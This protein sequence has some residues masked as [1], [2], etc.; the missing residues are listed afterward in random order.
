MGEFEPSYPFADLTV[1]A[2]RLARTDGK[3]AAQASDLREINLLATKWLFSGYPGRVDLPATTLAGGPTQLSNGFGPPSPSTPNGRRERNANEMMASM[4]PPWSRGIAFGWHRPNVVQLSDKFVRNR[5][6][7]R[8]SRLDK[9]GMVARWYRIVLPPFVDLPNSD[10]A[11][12]TGQRCGEI[13]SKFR[14]G[15]PQLDEIN[16]VR[17]GHSTTPIMDTSSIG[18]VWKKFLWKYF[19]EIRSFAP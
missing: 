9:G 14:S 17:E 4:A 2:R 5:I 15:R 16:N 10:C 19:P 11:P 7:S 6:A 3:T 13:R 8:A 12:H 18:Q 1:I